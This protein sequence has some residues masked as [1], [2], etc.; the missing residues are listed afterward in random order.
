MRKVKKW[1]SFQNTDLL[2]LGVATGED[3]KVFGDGT[4]SSLAK[5]PGNGVADPTMDASPTGV[6]PQQMLEAEV[7]S[8]N[9]K[10][11]SLNVR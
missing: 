5:L 3:L 10:S 6:D 1:V 9:I 11:G 7:L 8:V 4:A 2:G